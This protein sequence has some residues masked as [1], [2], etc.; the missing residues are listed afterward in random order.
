MRR[1]MLWGKSIEKKWR[2]RW[3]KEEEKDNRIDERGREE[4]K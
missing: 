3:N 1:K 4:A 2:R